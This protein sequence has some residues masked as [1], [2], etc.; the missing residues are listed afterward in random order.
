LGAN[1]LAPTPQ[2]SETERRDMGSSTPQ[3]VILGVRLN[4]PCPGD[5]PVHNEVS[6]HSH[7]APRRGIQSYRGRA[8]VLV[9]KVTVENDSLLVR[10]LVVDTR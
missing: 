7:L 6:L 9:N 5:S 2:L 10:T 4:Q 3:M 8:R 1:G